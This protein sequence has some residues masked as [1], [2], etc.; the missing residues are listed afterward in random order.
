V[1]KGTYWDQIATEGGGLPLLW[2]DHRNAL[3]GALLSRWLGNG[4]KSVALVTDLFDDAFVPGPAKELKEKEFNVIGMDISHEMCRRARLHG[5]VC[6]VSADVLNLPFGGEKSQ[7]VLS[8]STL[9][10][11]EN[12]ESIILGLKEIHR[13]LANNGMLILTLDNPANPVVALRNALPSKFLEALGL[14]PY[15]IGF[16]LSL[17]EAMRIPGSG[18][19]VFNACP[20]GG[21][22]SLNSLLS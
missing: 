4:R 12:R 10:H 19:E 16:T 5:H 20:S 6:V 1:N 13:V 7:L 21:C 2:H 11:L 22:C 3:H 9:D 18:G 14:I 17:S 8:L 15:C